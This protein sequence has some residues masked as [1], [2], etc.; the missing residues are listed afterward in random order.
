MGGRVQAEASAFGD[1]AEA[2]LS[3]TAELEA[4]L[5]ERD[6]A[7]TRYGARLL[8]ATGGRSLARFEALC[9]RRRFCDVADAV[10]KARALRARP[11]VLALAA[12]RDAALLRCDERIAEAR[13]RLLDAAAVLDRFGPLG[14]AVRLGT[15]SRRSPS[16]RTGI[17]A[18][19]ERSGASGEA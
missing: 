4:A 2:W 13:A 5:R 6:R 12:E 8:R 16:K 18:P 3:A 11:K 9:R 7:T 17:G 10:E 19:A 15:T 1:V 14:D